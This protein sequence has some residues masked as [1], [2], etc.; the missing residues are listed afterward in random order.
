MCLQAESQEMTALPDSL[1]QG[2]QFQC[3]RQCSLLPSLL[4]VLNEQDLHYVGRAAAILIQFS[5]SGLRKAEDV[6]APISTK[7]TWKKFLAPEFG[8]ADL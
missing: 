3:L 1:S 5:S 2:S 8:L 7:E 6:W 4:A